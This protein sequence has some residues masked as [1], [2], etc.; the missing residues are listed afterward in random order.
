MATFRPTKNVCTLN[1]DD[2]FTY[3]LP[4]HE[5]EADKIDAAFKR[6]SDLAPKDRAGVD[7]AYNKALDLIDELLG[8]GAG[9]D[10]MT[11]FD[12]PGTLEVI[13]V[14]SFIVKEWTAAYSE[15]TGRIETGMP[16]FNPPV[17]N[18]PGNRGGRR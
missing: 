3:E 16:A 5:D 4:L 1:F 15:A 13:E 17:Q 10:I 12:H 11:V 2:K 6:I 7:E 18:R 9:A 8:E 14:I